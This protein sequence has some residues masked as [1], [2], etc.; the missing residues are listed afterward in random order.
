MMLLRRWVLAKLH[1]ITVTDASVD[2]HG[3]VSIDEALMRATGIGHGEEVQ[4]VNLTTGA[5]WTTYALPAEAGQFTLNGG[6]ARLGVP[7]DR[8]VVMTYGLASESPGARVLFL[9]EANQVTGS[10]EYPAGR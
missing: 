7:G 6:S 4:V 10:T 8:C 2:Y 3:S 1:G 5:R 9:D